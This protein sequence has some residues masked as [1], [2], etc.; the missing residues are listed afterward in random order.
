MSKVS[1][2]A[3]PPRLSLRSQHFFAKA[4]LLKKLAAKLIIKEL[5]VVLALSLLK[6]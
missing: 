2:R 4:T 6:G 5:L 3:R 1:M